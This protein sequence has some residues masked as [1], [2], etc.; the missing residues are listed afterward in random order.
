MKFFKAQITFLVKLAH[1]GTTVD[2]V[3]RKA[4]IC[5]ATFHNW[6]KTYAG[7]MPSN[8]KRRRGSRDENAKLK[9]F[10][11]DP[12]LDKAMLQDVLAKKALRPARSC[13]LVGMIKATGLAG[14]NARPAWENR[15]L[16]LAKT[17]STADRTFERRPLAR[18]MASGMGRPFGFLW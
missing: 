11:A 17:C 1:D 7:L 8:M 14:S 2:N 10:V 12:S 18:D 5:R 6:R 13:Q 3:C 16:C 15:K 4:G 9:Q